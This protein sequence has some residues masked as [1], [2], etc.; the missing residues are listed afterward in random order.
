LLTAAFRSFVTAVEWIAVCQY[1]HGW[2]Q[3]LIPFSRLCI[4]CQMQPLSLA[5]A[6]HANTVND[7]PEMV[8]SLPTREMLLTLLG[9]PQKLRLRL[10]VALARFL[11]ATPVRAACCEF[12]DDR[13]QTWSKPRLLVATKIDLSSTAFVE[14]TPVSQFEALV[15]H[16][17]SVATISHCTGNRDASPFNCL[18]ANAV[19]VIGGRRRFSVTR[20][21][22]RRLCDGWSRGAVVCGLSLRNLPIATV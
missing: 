16:S 8:A 1:S 10:A 2:L 9:N 15:G 12:Y 11:K 21:S 6:C 17:Q 3:D 5:E 7:L 14:L 19:V 4:C 13:K 18:D 22:G 20:S